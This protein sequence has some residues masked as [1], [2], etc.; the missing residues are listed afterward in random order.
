MTMPARPTVFNQDDKYKSLSTGSQIKPV[1]DTFDESKGVAGRVNSLTSSGSP[2]LEAARTRAA[3]EANSRGLRNST[4]A[5]QAGEQAVIETATPIATADAQMYQTQ[6]LKNQD[7]L[8]QTNQFN[9]NIRTN[10]GLA[11]ADAARDN[12]QF[13]RTLLEQARQYDTTASLERDRFQE[14]RRQF[15]A[16]TALERDRFN[17][18]RRQYDTGLRE[19]RRQFD[20]TTGLER[21]RLTQQEQ[22]FADEQRYRREELA[23]RETIAQMDAKSRENL[24]TIEAQF[25]SSIESNQNIANAWGT[26]MQNISQIQNNPELNADAK[27][28]LI[29]NQVA[30]FQSFTN[31]WNKTTGGNVDVSD[32]LDF[33]SLSGPGGTTQPPPPP[34]PPPGFLT[35]HLPSDDSPRAPRPAPPAP[36]PGTQQPW[37]GGDGA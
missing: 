16:T 30:S 5:L 3:Q 33:G 10:I 26:L 31:F 23:M 35:D 15:D 4:M 12:N 7:T 27:K 28:R 9:S 22:Q 6:Q 25:K 20:A 2:I 19:D 24:A 29:D 1:T 17:E 14:G 37:Y 8:N 36:A 11:G 18:G 13:G 34:P 32:L 21:D